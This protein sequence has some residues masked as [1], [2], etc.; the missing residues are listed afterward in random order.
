VLTLRDKQF[1]AIERAQHESF[2]ERLVAQ[3][4]E[5]HG[6]ACAR[7]PQPQLRAR[8]DA[9]LARAAEL[10]FR[11]QSSLA[12]FVHL[13]FGVAPG[14]YLHPQV[15]AALADATL[16]LEDRLAALPERLEPRVWDEIIANPDLGAW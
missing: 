4:R 6:E 8:I 12:T 7:L 11:H 5:H 13:M 3:V 16:P 2:V 10:G 15:K 9:G 1:T 14:F